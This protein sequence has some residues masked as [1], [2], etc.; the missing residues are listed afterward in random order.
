MGAITAKSWPLAEK[1]RSWDKDAAEGRIRTWAGGPGKEDV[2]WGKYRSCFMWYDADDAENFTGYKFAYADVIDGEPHV[3]FRALAA[4]IGVLNGARGGTKIPSSDVPKVYAQAA[5]Q[6][7]R[8]DEEPPELKRSVGGQPERRTVP[9]EARVEDG[10]DGKP[11]VIHG[12]SAVFNKPADLMDW[13]GFREVVRP[14]A[15]TRT[16]KEDDIRGLWNHNTDFVLGRTKNGTTILQEDDEGLAVEIYPPDTQYARDFT[17]S[18]R[19]GDVDQMSFRF[20]VR[21]EGWSTVEGE[22]LRELLEVRLFDVSPVAFPAYTETSV[23][24]RSAFV[25]AGIDGEA[26]SAVLVRAQHGLR[27]SD[28]D[29]DVLES[30]IAALEGYLPEAVRAKRVVWSIHEETGIDWSALADAVARAY[31]AKQHKLAPRE[32][33]REVIEA[34]IKVLEAYLPESDTQE[35]GAEAKVDGA[36]ARSWVRRRFLETAESRKQAEKRGE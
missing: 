18:I 33:Q 6:Y 34:G 10:D 12:H 30:A 26:L 27:M 25:S 17:E 31:L 15:F 32:D 4:I 2:D 7:K 28:T 14:G 9:F 29:R 20:D 13:L 23:G 16:I 22:P 5:K 21:E 35:R 11:T 3:V 24:V 36:Q 1:D 19:R 8:F